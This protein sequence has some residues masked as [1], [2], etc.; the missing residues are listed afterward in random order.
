M[1]TKK[2]TTKR[3]TSKSAPK[4]SSARRKT[5]SSKKSR[6]EGLVQTNGKSYTQDIETVKRLEELLEVGKTNPF[7][8]ADQ[9]IFEENI[10]SMNL[11]EM[12]EVAVRAGIFPNGNKTV[13]KNK[14]LKAFKNQGFGVVDTVIDKGVPL[15][16]DPENPKHRAVIDYLNNT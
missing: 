2:K 1:S 16:L 12:Q 5:T 10:A 6:V 15:D 14:L 9:R 3:A 13:L 7:G 11:S 8:T 4:K